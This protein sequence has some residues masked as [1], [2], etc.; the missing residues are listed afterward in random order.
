MLYN[1]SFTVVHKCVGP[2]IAY[3][4]IVYKRRQKYIASLVSICNLAE[5]YFQLKIN[6]QCSSTIFL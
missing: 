6:K 1:D 3:L 4:N 2:S 5:L